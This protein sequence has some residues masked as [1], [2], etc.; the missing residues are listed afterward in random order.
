MRSD[1]L[2]AALLLTLSMLCYSCAHVIGRA[3]HAELP[4]VG[5]SFWRWLLAVAILLPLVAP[6]LP[7]LMPLYRQHWRILTLLG[8]FIVGSTTLVLVGLNYATATNTSLINA[9]QPTLTALLCWLFLGERMRARQWLGLA[10]AL[11]GILSI[12]GRGDLAVLAS[13][14]FNFG[15]LIVLGAMFGF[16][17]YG[18][19]IRRIPPDFNVV[20]SLFAIVAL[21]TLLLLPF[22]LLETA[23]ARPMLLNLNSVLAVIVMA[24]IVSVL[25]ML[26][27]TRGNQLIGASRAAV[28][29]NLIP[30]F[31]ALLSFLLL[32]ESLALY[33][34]AGGL[35]VGGG[36]W[37]AIRH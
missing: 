2:K 20:E 1:H 12:I 18:L 16:A 5:L 34:L 24:L 26:M 31:G 9:S 11:L 36:M 3:V 6:A 17:A 33:H 27:W 30:L 35:L 7:R 32:D 4:P 13:L 14:D 19:N 28:Y 25:G 22:Y 15:E 10:I 21:G 23:L 29:V 37:L 8:A